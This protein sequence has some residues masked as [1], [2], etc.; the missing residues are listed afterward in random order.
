MVPV[1]SRSGTCVSPSWAHV[2]TL[3]A[4]TETGP[5][6]TSC[7]SQRGQYRHLEGS[8]SRVLGYRSVA[9]NSW[10]CFSQARLQGLGERVLTGLFQ[11][12]P[13]AALGGCGEGRPGQS[14]SQPGGGPYAGGTSPAA[15]LRCG[16]PAEASPWP[17]RAAQA[18]TVAVRGADERRAVAPHRPGTLASDPRRLSKC[19]NTAGGL[20]GATNQAGHPETHIT[21]AQV[22]PKKTYLTAG[23]CAWTLLLQA[24]SHM[25]DNP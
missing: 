14:G 8:L 9:I 15:H 25:R 20:P 22:T 17:Q 5:V 16:L 1:S 7:W 23:R 24:H 6:R 13:S 12:R 21:S 10:L 4:R 11:T 18:G 2:S 19:D 3:T